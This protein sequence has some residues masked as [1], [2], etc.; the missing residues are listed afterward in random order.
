M[1]NRKFGALTSS[2]NPE[3]LA[4]KVKGIVLALSSIIILLA[5]KLFGVQLSPTDMVS[6]ATQVGTIAGGVWAVYGSVLHVITLFYK[7]A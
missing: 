7:K 5:S 2:Q 4:N 6:L 1:D 3:Q